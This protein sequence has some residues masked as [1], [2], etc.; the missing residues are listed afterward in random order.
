MNKPMIA[1]KERERLIAERQERCVHFTGLFGPG[2]VKH[3]TCGA[4]VCYDD[5][6]VRH[7]PQIPYVSRGVGYMAGQSLPC[8]GKL[9][10]GGAICAKRE[11]PTVEQATAEIDAME[12]R[13]TR[14]FKARAAIIEANGGRKGGS[15]IIDCPNCGGKLGYSVAA[16]NG[17]IHARC[18]TENCAGWME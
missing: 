1:P 17:H 12:A 9:N 18:A 7:D 3:E 8:S 5:V 10:H 16:C 14:E 4:G 2:M 11:T 6:K 15:G 13:L